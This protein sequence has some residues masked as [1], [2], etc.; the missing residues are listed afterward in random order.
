MKALTWIM[1]GL[2]L[3]ACAPQEPDTPVRDELAERRAWL[4]GPQGNAR[5]ITWSASGLGIRVLTPGTGVAP[6]AN[7]RVRVNYIAKLK[8]GQ[9]IDDSRAKGPARDFVVN[10]LIP[11]WAEG[12]AALRPG[13]KAVLF[14]PPSLGY[15]NSGGGGLP[16]GAGLI[17]EVE[18][19]AVN[20]PATPK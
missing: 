5:D 9:V 19:V 15:G 16:A 6:G 20:P 1:V 8:D 11:G 3:T 14:I 2:A 10:R 4:Y 17:F 13:G 18:L 7:D 12:I